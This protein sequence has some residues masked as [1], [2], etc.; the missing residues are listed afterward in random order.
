VHYVKGTEKMLRRMKD[1]LAKS[2]TQNAQLQAQL[3]EASR[4]SQDRE[5]NGV[6]ADESSEERDRLSREISELNSKLKDETAALESK[7]RD[8][9]SHLDIL[10]DERDELKSQVGHLQKQLTDSEK[11]VADAR[12]LS[13][14]LENENMLLDQRVQ[15]AE[16]KV[17]M[18]LDQ[19]EHSVDVYRR[20]MA[21]PSSASGGGAGGGGVS[22]LTRDSLGIAS[23]T[24]GA[25]DSL[26]NE[27]DQLRATWEVH[28][29]DFRE[30]L[31]AKKGRT[32]SFS[33]QPKREWQ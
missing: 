20:S 19:V 21:P 25:L 11:I 31:V 18:L 4:A 5:A 9:Q 32:Q 17:S 2:K 24:S 12:S 26:A 16:G 7:L 8:M 33:L 30:S 14:R 29:R 23:R 27:L 1:E 6:E 10:S 15:E 3:E 13:L 22:P 28:P